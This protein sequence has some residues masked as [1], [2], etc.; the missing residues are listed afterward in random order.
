MF[1]LKMFPKICD[2]TGKRVSESWDIMTEGVRKMLACFVNFVVTRGNM[3]ELGCDMGVLGRMGNNLAEWVWMH[4][5]VD[6]R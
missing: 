2:R 5:I 3:K 4:Y 1:Y 6:H